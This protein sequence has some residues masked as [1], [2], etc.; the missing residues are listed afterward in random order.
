MADPGRRSG[1]GGDAGGDDDVDVPYGNTGFKSCDEGT[2][3]TQR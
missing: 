1:G 2:G 3:L